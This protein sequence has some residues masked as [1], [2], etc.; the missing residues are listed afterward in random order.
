MLVVFGASG[1]LTSRKLMPAI[2]RLGLRRLLP[3]GFSVVGVGRTPMT[4]DDFLARM[5]ALVAEGGGGGDETDH[6]WDAFGGGGFR[7]VAGDYGDRETYAQ[8]RQLFAELDRDRG[9]SGN[10]LYYLA[11]PPATFPIIAAA[12][13]ESGLSRP[14][15]ADAFVR[16]VIEK[17]Y[18][19]DEASGAALD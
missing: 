3:G 7:Y 11:T 18:G 2:E 13:G 6:V 15:H 1:D 17:P 19:H 10:R 4:D 12:L 8:L 9:A 5:R 14:E 16:I